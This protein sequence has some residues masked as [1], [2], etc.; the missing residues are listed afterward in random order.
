MTHKQ[1]LELDIIIAIAVAPPVLLFILVGII[2]IIV[3]RVTTEVYEYESSADDSSYY[4][5]SSEGDT[6]AGRALAEAI[7][8]SEES[9]TRT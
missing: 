2:L 4:S 3:W 1:S 7:Y 9:K 6:P 5:Y 8:S